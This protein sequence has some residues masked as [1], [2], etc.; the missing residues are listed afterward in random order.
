MAHEGPPNRNDS[1]PA[2]SDRKRGSSPSQ[3]GEKDTGRR[4]RQ[5]VYRAP[6]GA[7]TDTSAPAG[8]AETPS[9][10]PLYGERPPPGTARRVVGNRTHRCVGFASAPGPV[11]ESSSRVARQR[12]TPPPLQTGSTLCSHNIQAAVWHSI[13]R[14]PIPSCVAGTLWTRTGPPFEAGLRAPM[15]P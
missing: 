11:I 6:Q 13:C 15:R 8:A 2:P 7:K 4:K 5:P 1:R 9:T 10:R 3:G 14:R 12:K